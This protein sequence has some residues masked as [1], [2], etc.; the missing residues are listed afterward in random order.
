M[1]VFTIK[2][3]D[4]GEGIAEA[5]LVEWNV[6]IGDIVREDE[7]FAAVMTDKATVE[8]PSSVTGKVLWLGAEVGDT[9]AIGADL[10]RLEISG[11]DNTSVEEPLT[12]SDQTPDK[13]AASLES[14][15]A[16]KEKNPAPLS[17]PTPIPTSDNND[18]PLASPAVRLRAKDAGLDLQKVSGS[19]QGGIITHADLD[20]FLS[21][22]KDTD[23]PDITSIKITGLRR[24]IAE[25]MTLAKSRI[26]HIT[27]I[28]EVDMTELEELRK[29]LNE[30]KTIEMPK[31]T[32]LPF[33]M[34]AL[35]TA[36]EDQPS[37]NAHFDDE[38]DILRQS[39]SVHIGIAAQTQNGLMVPVVRQCE[40]LKIRQMASELNRVTE[41]AKDGTATRDELTGSTITITS[42][43]PLGALATTPIINHPEVAIIGINKMA[44]R[45][46]WDG[47]EFIPRKMMNISCSFDHRVIDG[48]DAAVFV[49]RIK[50]LL[51][52]PL[53]IFL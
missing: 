19:G 10:I 41:A 52:T 8:I 18:K 34:G 53:L 36:V 9:I 6:A 21:N 38:A 15:N 23:N 28:E 50:T 7:T 22:H 16:P 1:G 5:E 24:K 12:A 46:M 25:K 39:N 2:V 35:V 14:A 48:W 32:L 26:P 49:K 17:S 43:G 11:S 31:L 27:I 4:V 33:M 29:K 3:P 30:D 47:E 20:S 40:T 13:G 45:P 44:I 37:F 51:E 42:L